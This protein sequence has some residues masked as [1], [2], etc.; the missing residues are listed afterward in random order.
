M[1]INVS[2]AKKLATWHVIAPTYDALTVII[3]A[4]SQQTALKKFHPQAYR[5][6]AETITL[7]DVTDP[8]LGVTIT[9]SITI[10]T[11][12]IGAG[13]ADLNLTPIILDIGVT[14]A[15]TLA[16]FALDL[17]TDPHT[18]VHHATEAPAHTITAETHHTTDLHHAGV[19]P[20]MTVDQEHTHPANTI[21]KSQKDHLPVHIKHT[22]SPKTGNTS[23]SPLMTCPQSTI[24]L[25]NRTVIQRMI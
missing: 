10:L 18:A 12:E 4:M 14:V 9:I 21:K 8:H 24:A 5:Q 2:N 13:S 20:E 19:S 17:S 11:K 22:G 3:M 25:M 1:M 16:E 7:V 15:V 6:D 23:K